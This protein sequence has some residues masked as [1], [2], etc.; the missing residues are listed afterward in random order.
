[1]IIGYARVS[2]EEQRIDLQVSA[3]E[4]AGCD[5][6]F[7]DHGVSGYKFSRGGLRSAVNSLKKDGTLVVWRLAR[8]GRSLSG[9][10]NL[11][12]QLG[13]R[14]V[15]F[16]SVTENIDTS[17]SGGRLM[18][19]M[20]AALAEFERSLI[21]ERTKAGMA[22]AKARGCNVGRPPLLDEQQLLT[23]WCSVRCGGANLRETAA[24]FGVSV[25]TLQRGISALSTSNHRRCGCECER[26]IGSA[27]HDGHSR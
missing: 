26:A 14:G 4:R 8:L 22:A 1:M 15:H 3:L 25:R 21:S 16:R 13:S 23:A 9:L 7:A 18:F 2:T 6:I 11:M 19:H 24:E 20:M 17:S 27:P 10:V 12:E 5:K